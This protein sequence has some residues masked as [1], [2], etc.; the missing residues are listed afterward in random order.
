MLTGTMHEEYVRLWTNNKGKLKT[1]LWNSVTTRYSV[2]ILS[3]ATYLGQVIVFNNAR[4]MIGTYYH[5]GKRNA[6]LTLSY[7]R[8]MPHVSSAFLHRR[9]I[10]EDDSLIWP[11]W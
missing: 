1:K 4:Y 8:D 7:K 5:K 11:I 6:I 10:G 3:S 9:Y 2:T